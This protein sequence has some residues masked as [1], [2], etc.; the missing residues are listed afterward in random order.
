MVPADGPRRYRRIAGQPDMGKEQTRVTTETRA[1]VATPR[2]GPGRPP[3]P[4]LTERRRKEII[5]TATRLFAE[6]GY[7]ATTLDDIARELGY[8][9]GLVYHYFR[10][11]AEIVHHAILESIE[12]MLA[13]QEAV[14]ASSLPPDEKL[15][16]VVYDYVHVCLFGYQQY[17]VILADRAAPGRNVEPEGVLPL[18]RTFVAQYRAIIEEGI[19]AGVF[20]PVD[21]AVAALTLIQGIIGVARWYRPEGRLSR[22]EICDQVT[23]MMVA[24]IRAT[25]CPR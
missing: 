15:R 11:K 22:G 1:A 4:E 20:R 5:A 17:L 14:I 6:R 23:T 2:R 25:D 3:L 21:S 16:R 24:S 12:P 7:Q 8:T 9:K 10:S 18:L 19:A 13:Q